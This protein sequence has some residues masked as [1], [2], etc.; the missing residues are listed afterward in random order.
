MASNWSL[1]PQV[2]QAKINLNFLLP[3]PLFESQLQITAFPCLLLANGAGYEVHGTSQKL[4]SMVRFHLGTYVSIYNCVCVCVCMCVYVCISE[5]SEVFS[6][7][8]ESLRW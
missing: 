5:I 4:A 3:I 7:Y 8:L 2:L 1:S 6:A